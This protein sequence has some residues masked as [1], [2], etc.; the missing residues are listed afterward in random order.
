MNTRLTERREEGRPAFGFYLSFP[1]PELVEF[2][3]YIGFDYVF[4]DAEHF[5]FH[6]ETIQSIVR[7][8]QLTGMGT[9]VRV[10]K[11]DQELILGYLETG[12]LGIMV[13]HTR[14]AEDARAAVRSVKYPPVGR[15]GAGSMSRAGDYGIDQTPDEHIARINQESLVITL[16]EDREGVENLPEILAVEGVDAFD[17]GPSDLAMSLGHPGN[18]AHPEVQEVVQEAKHRITTA[19][20]P[21]IYPVTTVEEGKEALAAGAR[22][23][24]LSLNDVLVRETATFL[25]ELRGDN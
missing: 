8:G 22:F 12:V 3:G 19:G 21:L 13:P 9:V 5:A 11:N 6:I 17:V 10:P 4:V 15:R 24:E 2:F 7:A 16:I 25:A 14:T 20:R 23:I 18:A 1:S